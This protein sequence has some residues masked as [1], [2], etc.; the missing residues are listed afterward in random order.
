VYSESPGE[1]APKLAL[2]LAA[3]IDGDLPYAERMFDVVSR[4]DDAFTSAAFGLARV[5]VA[6]GDRDGAVAAYRRVPPSSAAYVDAQVRLARLLGT[7]TTAGVPSRSGLI[8][9]SRILELLQLDP[10]RRSALARDLLAASVALLGSGVL[11]P[12][13]SV[14]VVGCPLR[15]D[16]LRLGLERAYREL[17]KHAATRQARYELVDLANSVRP[18]TLT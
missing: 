13:D 4:T 15:E 2:A 12:D 1:L 3:E 7:F 8:E 11:S 10:G 17:A 18:R 5:R 9:A 16:A 14:T 6:R